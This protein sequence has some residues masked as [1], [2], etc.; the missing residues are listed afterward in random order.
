MKSV[1][2]FLLPNDC[3]SVQVGPQ[4]VVVDVLRA[5]T[6]IC[7]A[8]L[9]GA[10]AVKPFAEI[11]SARRFAAGDPSGI[12]L[13]GE[14]GGSRV[15]GFDLGNSPLEYVSDV[16]RGK[17][18]AFTT[19]NGTRAM[20]RCRGAES[21]L[22]GAFCNLSLLA[23]QLTG[24]N[25]LDIV[26]AGTDGKFSVEDSA[27]AGALVELFCKDGGFSLNEAAETCLQLWQKSRQD[28][29]GVMRGGSGGRNLGR[30]GRDED[31]EFASRLDTL[32][33]VPRLDVR[34]WKIEP[35]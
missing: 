7:S 34:D 25:Q 4:V 26:C 31:I 8:L 1:R 6:T 10:V 19:T 14:R 21:V 16:V 15:P 29:L 33:V 11:E 13:G 3:G 30:L 27:F 12:L 22:V 18:I 2:C 9:Q 20:E 17:T 28:L 24:R 35:A 5:S 32:E 23:K